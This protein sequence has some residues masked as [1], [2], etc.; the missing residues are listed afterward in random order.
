MLW[1]RRLRRGGGGGGSSG[2]WLAGTHVAIFINQA[3]RYR[4]HEVLRPGSEALA[5]ARLPRF[6]P[7]VLP[8]R[9]RLWSMLA[10]QQARDRA[11]RRAATPHLP[12]SLGSR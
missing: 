2:G 7:D 4:I 10:V 11:R 3:T 9:W 12:M 1:L 5:A 6:Q 8:V